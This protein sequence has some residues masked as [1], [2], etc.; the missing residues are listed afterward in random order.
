MKK[1]EWIRLDKERP[2]LCIEVLVWDEDTGKVYIAW[3]EGSTPEDPSFIRYI[4]DGERS[5]FPMRWI[6]N[7]KYWMPLP[8]NPHE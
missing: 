2:G 7:V 3:D 8:G 6:E 1:S 4:T 5:C